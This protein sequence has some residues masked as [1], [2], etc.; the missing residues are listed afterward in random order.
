MDPGF[1]RDDAKKNRPEPVFFTR[2]LLQLIRQQ[3]QN[4][5]TDRRRFRLAIIT[6]HHDI[7]GR[8]ALRRFDRDA[9]ALGF[10]GLVRIAKAEQLAEEAFLV[11]CVRIDVAHEVNA[12]HAVAVFD[13]EADAV[14]RQA[15][16]APGA[17]ETF[18][19]FDLVAHQ[20]GVQRD[21]RSTGHGGFRR[22]DVGG[23]GQLGDQARQECRLQ[24][25]IV[26]TRG[27]RGRFLGGADHYFFGAAMADPHF[28]RAVR[29]ALEARAELVAL[30]GRIGR[31]EHAANGAADKVLRDLG[32][33]FVPR[34]FHDAGGRRI[35]GDLE[36]VVF[37]E[38]LDLWPEL[39]R[40]LLD[41]QPF[42]VARTFHAHGIGRDRADGFTGDSTLGRGDLGAALVHAGRGGDAAAVRHGVAAVFFQLGQVGR[43]VQRR[44]AL[45]CFVIDFVRPE[46]QHAAAAQAESQGGEQ[47]GACGGGRRNQGGLANSH[48]VSCRVTAYGWDKRP[49][50]RRAPRTVSWKGADRGASGKRRPAGIKPISASAHLTGTGFGSTNSLACRSSTVLLMATA[51]A[52]SPAMAASHNGKRLRHIL[53]QRDAAA[54]VAGRIFHADDIWH[55][56]QADDGLIRHVGDGTAR[57]VVQDDREVDRF[58]NRREVAKHA[59]LRWAVVV[60]HDLQRR[61]GAGFLGEARQADGLGSGI[62]AGAGDDRD[63][64]GTMLDGQTNQFA[65]FIDADGGRLARGADDHD[66]VGAF[67]DM[68][69]DQFF[70]AILVQAAVFVHRGDDCYYAALNHIVSIVPLSKS[71]I[72]ADSPAPWVIWG[73]IRG[74]FTS[75]PACWKGRNRVRRRRCAARAPCASAR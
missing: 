48:V 26:R 68:P 75:R 74:S 47:Q 30:A 8:R 59:L 35:L 42:L 19:D 46:A 24:A 53:Q 9:I 1:R 55:G 44:N 57:H 12:L 66:A 20:L 64:A 5:G 27:P 37:P 72:V 50:S 3:P 2:R 11:D 54:D 63:T 38:L 28:R 14:Q 33:V 71:L 49:A 70:Q 39:L 69:V 18:I 62:G 51:R 25:R 15:D 36:A 52:M 21:R 16:T 22:L 6:L 60:R 10:L 40:R 31:V 29:Q 7:G 67:G 58:G 56:G 34:R 17:V 13:G 61:I 65:V 4:L 32:A 43:H 45:R 73:R 41:D 23:A